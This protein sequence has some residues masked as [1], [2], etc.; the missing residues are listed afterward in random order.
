MK[1]VLGRARIRCS[2]DDIDPLRTIVPTVTVRIAANGATVAA[3]KPVLPG[4]LAQYIPAGVAL[5]LRWQTSPFA[6]ALGPDGL[7]LDANGTG[8]L[9]D[10]STIGRTVLGGRKTRRVTESGVDTGLRLT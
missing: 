7:L 2:K 1:A 5:R 8:R 10:T 3:L 9:G 6:D 4:M